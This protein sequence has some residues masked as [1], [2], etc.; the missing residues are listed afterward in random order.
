MLLTRHLTALKL[1][2]NIFRTATASDD[3]PRVAKPSRADPSK[4]RTC[5]DPNMTRT[6]VPR[7]DTP[8]PR[9][10]AQPTHSPT[11]RFQPRPPTHRYSTHNRSLFAASAVPKLLRREAQHSLQ[12]QANA[13]LHPTTGKAMSY[14]Q[15]MKDPLTKAMWIRAMTTELA[16]LARLAQGMD[17]IT[18]G[19]DT[20]FYFSHDEIKNIPTDQTVTYVRI[21]VDYR[22]Q[23]QDP[24]RVR[25]TVG[26]NLIKYRVKSPPAPPT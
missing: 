8:V 21:V 17:G 23:K 11:K 20:I 3:I 26:S 5:D 13:V 10:A 14:K 12:Q 1:L 25:I 22:P 7:V 2:A 15:L 16:R 19:T 9:V 24:N 4:V 18:E 6:P